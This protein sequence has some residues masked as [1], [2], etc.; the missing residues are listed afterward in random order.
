MEKPG[1][2]L[3]PTTEEQTLCKLLEQTDMKG[4]MGT[5]PTTRHEAWLLAS[6]LSNIALLK[7]MRLFRETLRELLGNGNGNGHKKKLRL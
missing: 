5:R 7:E 2:S 4:Y 1:Q 6:A 3:G